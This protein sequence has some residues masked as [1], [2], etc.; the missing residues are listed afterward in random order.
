MFLKKLFNSD[1]YS[2]GYLRD[3][4]ITKKFENT[5]QV[6]KYFVSPRKIDSRDLCLMPDQQGDNP[7]CSAYTVSGFLEVILW[8]KNHYPKK[9]DALEM[10]RVSKKFDF[11]DGEGTSLEACCRSAEHLGIVQNSTIRFVDRGIN[12][13]KFSIHTHSVMMGAFN[14]T[15]DWFYPKKNGVINNIKNNSV[16]HHAV[17]VCGYD[18]NGIYIKNSWGPK[19]GHY[20]FAHLDWNLVNKQFMYGMILL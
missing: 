12:P 9:I 19:W 17:L 3:T 16:G 5:Q 8:K 4:N 1:R 10:Y 2:A 18:T 15:E 7:Y 20:G 14:I 11:Y 6:N 13:I